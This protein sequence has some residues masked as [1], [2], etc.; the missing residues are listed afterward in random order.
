MAVVHGPGLHIY[1]DNGSWYAC[2]SSDF[3]TYKFHSFQSVRALSQAM[4]V[5]QDAVVRAI[6][7]DRIFSTRAGETGALLYDALFAS[8]VTEFYR[9]ALVMAA[10]VGST[11]HAELLTAA[12]ALAAFLFVSAADMALTPAL[13]IQDSMRA[14]ARHLLRKLVAAGDSPDF[15]MTFTNNLSDFAATF[16]STH[17]SIPKDWPERIISQPKDTL[18]A[19]GH[20]VLSIECGLKDIAMGPFDATWGWQSGEVWFAVMI[21]V[22]LQEDRVGDA[23]NYLPI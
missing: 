12:E 9:G 20:E 21:H 3:D 15:G 2:V 4:L 13:H 17:V 22:P 5:G 23:R 1:I 14:P 6:D 19:K 16:S 8:T 18:G 11:L 10:A 7:G